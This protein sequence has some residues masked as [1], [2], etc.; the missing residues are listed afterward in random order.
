MPTW[1]PASNF[2]KAK[3]DDASEDGSL[4][5]KFYTSKEPAFVGVALAFNDSPTKRLLVESFLLASDDDQELAKILRCDEKTLGF[6]RRMFYDVS[7]ATRLDIFEYLQTLAPEEKVLKMMAIQYG[8][9][10]LKWFLF[11]LPCD[12]TIL[13]NAIKNTMTEMFFTINNNLPNNS[14][15]RALV[16]IYRSIS[17]KR[18]EAEKSKRNE[19]YDEVMAKL[20]KEFLENKD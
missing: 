7:H 12:E 9:N 5:R 14:P 13:D 10:F 19:K 6:Y 8:P 18:G 3:A 2:S 11:G 20:E 1:S 16:A 4:L 17:A 15:V